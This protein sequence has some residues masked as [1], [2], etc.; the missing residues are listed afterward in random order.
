M[1]NWLRKMFGGSEQPRDQRRERQ[2]EHTRRNP[3]AKI[4]PIRDEQP[5][6]SGSGLRAVPGA[7]VAESHSGQVIYNMLTPHM[8][9]F[10]GR[11]VGAIKRAGIAAK[12]TGQFSILVGEQGRELRLDHFYQ[13]A[14]DPT[15]VEQVVAEARRITNAAS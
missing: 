8:G 7:L 1:F 14:D 6:S 2:R 4:P 9:Q 15:I 3:P 5:S 12:G 10:M 11:C 13:P